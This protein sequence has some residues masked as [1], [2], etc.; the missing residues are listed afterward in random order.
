M[1]L[2]LG[3]GEVD[4]VFQHEGEDGDYEAVEEEVCE[5]TNADGRDYEEGVGAPVQAC[6]GYFVV[7]VEEEGVFDL[8]PEVG[9]HGW[10]DVARI[11]VLEQ[12]SSH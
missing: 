3:G 5:E 2:N 12:V 9:C 11:P 8:G 7:V 10:R 4:A 1:G 6:W